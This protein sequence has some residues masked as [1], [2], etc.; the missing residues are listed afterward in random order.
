MRTK[1]CA[2]DEGVSIGPLYTPSQPIASVP[3]PVESLLIVTV[4]E[5]GYVWQWDMPLQVSNHS[6]CLAISTAS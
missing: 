4:S 1:V 6:S 2:G 5:E 3:P